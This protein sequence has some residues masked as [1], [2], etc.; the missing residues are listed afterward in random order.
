MT[1][2]IHKYR[3]GDFRDKM[4][5][6]D[7]SRLPQYL[8]FQLVMNPIIEYLH[9]EVEDGFAWLWVLVNIDEQPKNYRFAVI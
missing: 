1:Q 8:D 4:W 6:K 9:F 3:L 5:T 2:I 7:K